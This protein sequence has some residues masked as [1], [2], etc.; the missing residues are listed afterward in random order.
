MTLIGSVPNR[1]LGTDPR[2]ISA[3]LTNFDYITAAIDGTLDG[4]NLTLATRRKLGLSDSTTA[5]SGS[6]IIATQEAIAGGLYTTLTTPD[7]VSNIELSTP[8]I[9]FISVQVTITKT[10]G[11]NDDTAGVLVYMD[12]F[13][14]RSIFGT[15]PASGV[16]NGLFIQ[17]GLFNGS[18]PI[19]SAMV[20]SAA[21]ADNGFN[22]II[23]GNGGPS[24]TTSNGGHLGGSFVPVIADSGL[25]TVELRYA[26]SAG[27]GTMLVDH[28]RLYVMAQSL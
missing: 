24:D 19:V 14:V 25:H 3:L 18:A 13:H 5:R 9:I 20:Y 17:T 27:T 28:R 7:R 16:S 6:S 8:G 22:A 23:S 21:S 2:S 15:T 12:G 26:K 11:A 4:D 1:P 10:A